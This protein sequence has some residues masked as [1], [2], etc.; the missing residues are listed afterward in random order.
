[1]L[2]SQKISADWVRFF[3]LVNTDDG[4]ITPLLDAV[5]SVD[6]RT[7]AWKPAPDVTSIW[8]IV[9][10]VT[11]W[12]EDLLADLTNSNGVDPVDWPPVAMVDENSWA[13]A[14]ERLQDSVKLLGQQIRGMS[15]EDIYDA[16]PRMQSRRSVRLTNILIHNAYHAGQIVKLSQLYAASQK[17]V[18]VA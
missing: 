1:M 10:H 5:R 2:D 9:Y 4:W 8:E 17:P 15:V 3:E 18:A 16:P 6:A 12:V 11:G 7:A 14:Q 13:M